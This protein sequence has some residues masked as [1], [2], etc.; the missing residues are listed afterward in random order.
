MRD[1]HGAYDIAVIGGGPAGMMAAGRAAELGRSVI[2]VEKNRQLGVKLLITGKGR[3]NIAQAEFDHHQLVEQFGRPGRF[4]L[5]S[6]TAFGVQNVLE[7][8]DVRGVKTKVE[9]GKRVFPVSD[10]ARDV[11]DALAGY[12]VQGRVKVQ[13]NTEVTGFSAEGDQI[14]G[15]NTSQ[16]RIFANQYILCSGG[17]SYPATGSNGQGFHW[18]RELGHNVTPLKPALVPVRVKEG[19]VKEVQGLS[20]KNVRISLYQQGYQKDQRFGEALFTHFGLSGPIVLDISKKVGEILP[21]GEVKLYIDLK[22][23]LEFDRLDDRVQRDFI[24]YRNKDFK[25]CLTDLLPRT[26]IDPI[27]RMSGIH[28]EKQVNGVTREERHRLVKLLKG[29]ELTVQGLMGF[30]Q[31]IITSGGVKLKEVD[32]RTMRSRLLNNLFLA[33]EVLD[34]AGPTGGYNLQ[35]CWS[36]GFL[37]GQSAAKDTY[38]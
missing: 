7:F 6:L 29:L 19:W 24:K 4:L 26:L 15:I 9:R 12:L 32:P 34:I 20:L 35:V 23:S 21:H 27:I 17:C 36:T 22:P 31:A 25:N 13:L 28:P 1:R 30:D 37:A 38:Y 16:G 11:R 14:T 8:F 2:L 10:R 33:G 18:L 3:C 5:P